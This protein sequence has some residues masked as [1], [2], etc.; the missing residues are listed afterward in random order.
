MQLY[1]IMNIVNPYLYVAA[2]QYKHR[3]P[4]FL[5]A[6]VAHYKLCEPISIY[7]CSAL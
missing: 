2:A 7:N 6:T 4:I 1:H 5:Y 3:E